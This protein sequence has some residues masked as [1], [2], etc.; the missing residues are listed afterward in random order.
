MTTE[1]LWEANQLE[2]DIHELDRYISD[3]EKKIKDEKTY[4]GCTPSSQDVRDFIIK[5]DHDSLQLKIKKAKMKRDAL[6]LK[7]T[8][9]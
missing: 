5:T 4:S 8:K 3:C 6:K 1:K 9:L 2:N 7:F